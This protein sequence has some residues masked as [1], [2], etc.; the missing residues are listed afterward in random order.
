[1]PARFAAAS[2]DVPVG[3]SQTFPFGPNWTS[4]AIDGLF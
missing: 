2:K 1:M 4:T 3:T